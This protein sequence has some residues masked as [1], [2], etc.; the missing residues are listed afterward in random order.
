MGRGWAQETVG[1]LLEG[2]WGLTGYIVLVGIR[3]ALAGLLEAA[4]CTKGVVFV[5]F[6]YVTLV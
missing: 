3:S 2:L 5:H 4:H 1:N 6:S